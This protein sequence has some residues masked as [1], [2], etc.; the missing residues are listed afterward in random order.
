MPSDATPVLNLDRKQSL[1]MRL[2][3]IQYMKEYNIEHQPKKT[4][5]VSSCPSLPLGSVSERQ[6]PQRELLKHVHEQ[7]LH[8]QEHNQT[9]MANMR[10]S[11]TFQ[12]TSYRQQQDRV[13][14]ESIR[15]TERI[16]N[17]LNQS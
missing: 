9:H 12:Q 11:E 15:A 5:C 17:H 10:S 8:R 13:H 16:V 2:F 3:T 14:K 1:G 6:S 4:I 7:A